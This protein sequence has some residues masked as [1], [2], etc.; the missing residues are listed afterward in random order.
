MVQ[1][2]ICWRGQFQRAEADVVEGLVVDAEGLVCVLQELVDGQSGV[3]W[4]H[5]CVRDFRRGH[6][7]EG[8][9]DAVRVLL[10][11][12]VDNEG[13]HAGASATPQ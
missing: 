13:S 1:I 8:I 12:L 11:D 10:S 4:L 2:P 6:D 9:H 7:T 3:V 5:H